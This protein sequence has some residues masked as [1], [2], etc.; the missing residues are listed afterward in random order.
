MCFS[1][2]NVRSKLSKKEKE[3]LYL[4]QKECRKTDY[5]FKNK[6]RED[7]L[8]R[9]LQVARG[10]RKKRKENDEIDLIFCQK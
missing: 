7:T 6:A 4:Y 3:E 9:I 1:Q 8:E 2:L 5:E 10:F